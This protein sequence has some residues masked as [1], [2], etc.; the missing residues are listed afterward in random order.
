MATE[1][2]VT[3]W[4]KNLPDGSVEALFEGPAEKVS[5]AV[6]WCRKGPDRAF[7]ASLQEYAEQP[8]GLA[9]FQIRY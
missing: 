2:G 4:V 9:G 7:V 8:Q 1:L 6:E 5:A 3:G